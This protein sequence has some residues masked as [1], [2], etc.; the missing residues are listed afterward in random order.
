MAFEFEPEPN[1]I[2][3]AF[4]EEGGRKKL[5]IWRFVPIRRRVA[6]PS[7]EVVQMT[8]VHM[9]ASVGG[10]H[11]DGSR[12]DLVGGKNY[13]VSQALAD[14]LIVHGWAVG[15]LSRPWSEDEVAEAL[16][17]D[18]QITTPRHPGG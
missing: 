3:E 10:K 5:D 13:D 1:E 7:D 12:W 8:R 18:Q 9:V 11:P 14:R 17:H 15:A 4:V 2:L 16:S 6:R